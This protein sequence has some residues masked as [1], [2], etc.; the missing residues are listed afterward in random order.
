MRPISS[1]PPVVEDLA[2]EV[3]EEI[4]ARRVVE[5]IR[6]LGDGRVVEIDLFDVYRGEP[7]AAGHKSLAYRLTYQSLDRS[8]AEKEVEALRRRIVTAVEQ[9]TGGKLRS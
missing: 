9:A 4:T 8:L 3:G 5:V 7:L 1:Y 2:F 6:G